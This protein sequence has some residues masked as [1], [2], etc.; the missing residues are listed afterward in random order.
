MR[1]ALAMVHEHH[2]LLGGIALQQVEQRSLLRPGTQRGI[3][4][5]ST[6]PL[7]ARLIAFKEPCDRRGRRRGRRSGGREQMLYRHAMMAAGAYNAGKFR[8]SR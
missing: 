4:R 6:Q 1:Q 8:Q 3:A 7:L 5:S 2:L